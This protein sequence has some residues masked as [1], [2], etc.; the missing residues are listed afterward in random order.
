[1]S[2]FVLQQCEGMK[3]NHSLQAT[4][5]SGSANMSG[6]SDIGDGWSS[7][8]EREE[9]TG[10]IPKTMG[11]SREDEFGILNSRETLLT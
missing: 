11:N 8:V 1:M 5:T 3:N 9:P 7:Q 4:T 10:G 6:S 2:H